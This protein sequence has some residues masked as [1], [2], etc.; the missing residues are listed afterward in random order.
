[1]AVFAPVGGLS[2]YCCSLDCKITPANEALSRDWVADIVLPIIPLPLCGFSCRVPILVADAFEYWLLSIHAPP[3]L[4]HPRP[5]TSAEQISEADDV[6]IVNVPGWDLIRLNLVVTKQA[7]H[8][9]N[10]HTGNSCNE[11]ILHKVLPLE[12]TFCSV[13]R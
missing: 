11:A 8:V 1:M 5:E 7:E 2:V 6:Q 10:T 9:N 3:V 4:V 12:S 13:S